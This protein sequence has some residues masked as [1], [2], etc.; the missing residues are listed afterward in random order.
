[1]VLRLGRMS[2]GVRRGVRSMPQH[3]RVIRY[4]LPHHLWIMACAC[5]ALSKQCKLRL[6]LKRH[7]KLSCKHRLKLQLQFL[8]S[9]AMVSV[10]H[11]EV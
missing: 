6:I 5:K 1:M 10:H 8:R 3:P 4:F 2:R 9:M 11:G 7:C